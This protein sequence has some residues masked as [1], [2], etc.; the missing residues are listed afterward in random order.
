MLRRPMRRLVLAAASLLALASACASPCE[1]LAEKICACEGSLSAVDACERGAS[2]RE[3]ILNP[4]QEELDRC[5]SYLETC[6]CHA[7]G[8]AEGKRRCGLA[9]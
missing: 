4:T 8:T 7:L 9:E 5:E 6:D 2:E 1:E 3:G